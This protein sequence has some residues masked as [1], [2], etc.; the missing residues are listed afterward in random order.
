MK[1]SDLQLTYKSHV[2]ELLQ[3]LLEGCEIKK[4]CDD[5]AIGIVA[6]MCSWQSLHALVSCLLPLYFDLF[7]S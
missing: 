7:S 1:N 3:L 4:L 6:L 5:F 2:Q